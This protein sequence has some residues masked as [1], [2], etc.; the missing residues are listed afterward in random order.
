[1]C[2]TPPMLSLC[3]VNYIINH[4]FFDLKRKT[5]MHIFICKTAHK[6]V[7]GQ[8]IRQPV[9]FSY[10]LYSENRIDILNILLS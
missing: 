7:T 8:P 9:T 3:I 1:M 5:K 10:Y 4:H 6:K 2:G